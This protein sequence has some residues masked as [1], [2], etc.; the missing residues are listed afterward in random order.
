MTD[1]A[2]VR[3]AAFPVAMLCLFLVASGS[4]FAQSGP[5]APLIEQLEQ[6]R[7]VYVQQVADFEVQRG[8]FETFLAELDRL[9]ALREASSSVADDRAVREA[10][11]RAREMAIEL[12]RRS[13]VLRDLSSRLTDLESRLFGQLESRLAELEASLA[14]TSPG[15]RRAVLDELTALAEL[16]GR[17]LQPLAP[18][19][20]IE[21]EAIL[22]GLEEE[23]APEELENTADELT[24]HERRLVEHLQ[25]LE[26]HIDQL[27]LREQD[28]RLRADVSLFE[29]GTSTARRAARSEGGG[30]T[31]TSES[32]RDSGSGE[33]PASIDSPEASD[34]VNADGGM[35]PQDGRETA[36]DFLG[37]VG[38]GSDPTAAPGGDDLLG[39]EE[40]NRAIDDGDQEG[41]GE[42]QNDFEPE[43][44]VPSLIGVAR[45]SEDPTLLWLEE[46]RSEEPV[47]RST[48]GRLERLERER[49]DTERALDEVRRQRQQ[50]LQ[51]AEELEALE[52]L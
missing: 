8:D 38:A 27:E 41:F 19:P 2:T 17:Y 44:S 5:A 9:K 25:E 6:E 11:R 15:Q 36:D 26:R 14:Q 10:L 20:D 21:L 34:D 16:R 40:P 12:Q 42:P 39:S 33:V 50:L 18:V 23:T 30:L 29:E 48:R 45:Q 13:R 4:A 3:P 22:I 46:S 31:E 7:A 35:A 32:E 43:S 52:G 49:Q 47:G 51:R 37:D 24:D 28:R 1:F